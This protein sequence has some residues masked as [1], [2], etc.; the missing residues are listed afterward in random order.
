MHCNKFPFVWP[1]FPY[2]GCPVISCGSKSKVITHCCYTHYT[3][4]SLL[5]GLHSYTVYCVIKNNVNSPSMMPCSNYWNCCHKQW[6][7]MPSQFWLWQHLVGIQASTWLQF[8]IAPQKNV[9]QVTLQL[10]LLFPM[11]A[12]IVG[13]VLF[14]DAAGEWA[15]YLM[16]WCC[17]CVRCTPLSMQTDFTTCCIT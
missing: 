10:I 5:V 1:S 4:P 16:E 15:V 2:A 7:H 13:L 14:Q 11:G 9:S 12:M 17:R 6:V 8:I 3:S